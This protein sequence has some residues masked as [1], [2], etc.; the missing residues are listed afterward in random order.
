M[1]Y[2]DAV[3]KELKTLKQIPDSYLETGGIKIYTNLDMNSQKIL[4]NSVKT[5]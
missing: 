2:Q 4:E 3:M 1:Y 5:T